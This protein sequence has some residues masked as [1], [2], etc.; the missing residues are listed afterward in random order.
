MLENLF[1]E[2]PFIVTLGI[3]AAIVIIG[4]RLPTVRTSRVR[5]EQAPAFRLELEDAIPDYLSDA[6]EKFKDDWSKQWTYFLLKAEVDGTHPADEAAVG[7]LAHLQRF[8]ELIPV[9]RKDLE[10]KLEKERRRR[11]PHK[12]WMSAQL[13]DIIDR[14]RSRLDMHFNIT[15]SKLRGGIDN[16]DIS[17]QA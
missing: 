10:T 8:D 3:I 13:V 6:V 9:W 17:R 7:S 16:G 15:V 11:E 4:D 5:R 12:G 2:H 1:A 14:E